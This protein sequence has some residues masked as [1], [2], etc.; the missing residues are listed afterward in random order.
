MIQDGFGKSEKRT[1][2]KINKLGLM[3]KKGFDGVLINDL[4][5]ILD[6]TKR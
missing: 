3:V 2:E 1:N 6:S 4:M 5:R